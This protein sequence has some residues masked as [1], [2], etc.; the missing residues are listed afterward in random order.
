MS[1]GFRLMVEGQEGHTSLFDA[2]DLLRAFMDR[3]LAFFEIRAW[4][5]KRGWSG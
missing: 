1:E 2:P 5:R 3:W 4:A